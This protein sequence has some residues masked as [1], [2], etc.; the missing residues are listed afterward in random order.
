MFKGWL[1]KIYEV[2]FIED[3]KHRKPNSLRKSSDV[4]TVRVYQNSREK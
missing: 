4:N 1:D 2:K 3:I